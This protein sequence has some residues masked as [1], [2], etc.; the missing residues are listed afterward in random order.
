[1]ILLEYANRILEEAIAARI[2]NAKRENV[3]IICADFDGVSFHISNTA[4]AKN[5]LNISIN[6]RCGAELAKYGVEA[7]LKEVYGGLVVAPE[8]GYTA[9][10]Q[11][12][13]DAL[14]ADK[15]IAA[16]IGLFKRHVLSAP[17]KTVFDGI[18]AKN[19]SPNVIAIPYRDDE[20]FYLKPEGDRAIVIFAISFKDADDIV[21]SKVFLQEF[22][23]ARKS[24]TNV[25]SVTFSQKDPPGELAGIKGLKASDG[26]GFVS[27]VLFGTH[28]ANREKTINLI[29][30]FRNYLHYHIKC[31]KGYL[32]TRMRARVDSLLQILNRARPEPVNTVA[33][34]MT[35]KTFTRK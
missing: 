14:P 29:Q 35:G 1:M 27:F 30:T 32:H 26:N 16:K 18:A 15:D 2:A 17:Y 8:P 23:D 10:L 7:I 22:A 3:D 31:S 5:I 20:A 21:L 33:R 11:L 19:A 28:L 25:P 6:L 34:T 9:S 12:N 13:L 24:M 4:E